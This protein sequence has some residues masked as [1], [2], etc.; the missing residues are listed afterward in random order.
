MTNSLDRTLIQNGGILNGGGARV[1]EVD[2]AR[3]IGRCCLT[4]ERAELAARRRQNVCDV[5]SL[6]M[7][8]RKPCHARLE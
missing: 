5:V 6:E 2:D 1:M 8:S 4:P 3:Y 7:I